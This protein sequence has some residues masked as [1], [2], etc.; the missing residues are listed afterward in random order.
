MFK[1][2]GK[3][4]NNKEPIF[5]RIDNLLIKNGRVKFS[6]PYLSKAEIVK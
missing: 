2:M 3:T 4:Q 5:F 6:D 1:C